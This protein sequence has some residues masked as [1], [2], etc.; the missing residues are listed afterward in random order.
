MIINPDTFRFRIGIY[1][2]NQVPDVSGGITYDD[3][4]ITNVWA[5]INPA[6]GS[7][8]LYNQ[9]IN[10]VA[11]TIIQ[12]RYIDFLTS[13]YWIKHTPEPTLVT[14][15]YRILTIKNV[16]QVDRFQDLRCEEYNQT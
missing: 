3:Q 15:L 7:T 6:K 1:L 16:M 14:K 10:E 9:N 8:Y 12:I 4:L 13:E 5:N 11:T 2:R